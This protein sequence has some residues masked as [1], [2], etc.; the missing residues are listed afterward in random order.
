[1]KYRLKI[2]NLWLLSPIKKGVYK[3]QRVVTRMSQVASLHRHKMDK[4]IEYG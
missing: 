3:T 2:K 1:M 4:R